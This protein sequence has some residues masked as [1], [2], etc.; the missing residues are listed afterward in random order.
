[1]KH[2]AGG[3]GSHVSHSEDLLTQELLFDIGDDIEVV[4]VGG[5]KVFEGGIF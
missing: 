2:R 1:V 4:F 5:K 3:H